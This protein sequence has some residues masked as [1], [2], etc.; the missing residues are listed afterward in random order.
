MTTDVQPTLSPRAEATARAIVA[1]AHAALN[2]AANDNA[3]LAWRIADATPFIDDVRG[4]VEIDT[5]IARTIAP[6]IAAGVDPAFYRV[7]AETYPRAAVALFRQEVYS[8]CAM[9][10]QRTLWLL[11]ETVGFKAHI[12]N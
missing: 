5:R 11:L 9:R 10:R 12:T 6:V 1:C 3:G 2:L 8:R 4:H 7:D